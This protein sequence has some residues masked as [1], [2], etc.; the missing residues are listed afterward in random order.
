MDYPEELLARGNKNSVD[1]ISLL[2]YL[3]HR[4]PML[5]IDKILDSEEGDW[6]IGV[7]C[8]S[9]LEPYFQG[10]Y[11]NRPIM[12]GTLQLEALSQV[13]S[14]LLYPYFRGGLP[15]FTGVRSLRFFSIVK[16][17]DQLVLF[18]QIKDKPRGEEGIFKVVGDGYVDKKKCI[19][20]EMSFTIDRS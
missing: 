17:G 9:A 4:Y 14:Y 1:S 19:S 6:A 18:C 8:I 3:P 7:K 12:P 10:H 5:L 15:I 13:A 20:A 16:P 2:T 11:P